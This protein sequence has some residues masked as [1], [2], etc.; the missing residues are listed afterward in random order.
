MDQPSVEQL[1]VISIQYHPE[2]LR[3]M[4]LQT[5]V[6]LCDY[7]LRTD[8][9]SMVFI[10]VGIL[11]RLVRLL[12]LDNPQPLPDTASAAAVIARESEHRLVWACFFIDL[13]M[14]TAGPEDMNWKDHT[15]SIPLPRSD[16]SFLSPASLKHHVSTIDETGIMSI[17]DELDLSALAVLVMRLRIAGL[18]Y[19][20]SQ[21]W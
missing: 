17:I 1:M 12:G 13:F 10:L 18:Q 14:S 9:N 7:G 19:A 21:L 4:L 15:P 16:P 5:L 11:Y 6:L 8:Q 3:L 20:N 2:D